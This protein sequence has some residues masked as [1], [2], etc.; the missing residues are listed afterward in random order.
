M[1]SKNRIFRFDVAAEEAG[2]RLDQAAAD[3]YVELSRTL[4]RR[5]ID[6]GGVHVGGRRVRKSSLAL[7]EGERV[8]IHIDGGP[9]D[10]FRLSE[11]DLLFRDR[12]LLAVAKPAGVET[13][14]THARYK[15]TL[16]EALLVLLQD[17]FRPM[18]RPEIGMVQRLDRDT[19]G[20][21][22][23]SLHP[24]A[25]APLTKA[26]SERE[27]DKTYLALVSGVPSPAEGEIASNLQRMRGTNRVCS[28]KKGGKE[29]LTL[30]RT[31]Q[32]FDGAALLEVKIV[33]GRS[34]QI[35]AH[36]SEGG[37]PLIGDVRYGGPSEIASVPVGRQMLHS[38]RLD[39][40]HPVSNAPLRLV[41]PLPADMA[42]LIDRLSSRE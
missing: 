38:W 2:R 3:R 21:I 18:Q 32:K 10:P 34:H 39:I 4:I 12:Y 11:T 19:S 29:A 14:P 26:L 25:H 37:H 35:R 23:F 42:S 31:L 41:A 24:K 1:A 8:E 9:L 27:A 36:L 13:Q 20:V 6:L 30:Y 28:V 17:P 33:T 5:L 40:A 16:Y 7:K 15:G 22:V